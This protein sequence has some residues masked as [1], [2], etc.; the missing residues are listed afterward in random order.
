MPP[1]HIEARP[2]TDFAKEGLFNL[3]A[4][5]VDFDQVNALD[6]FSGTGSISLELVSRGCKSVTAI[7]QNEKHCA[8]IR[9]TCAEVFCPKCAENAR[10]HAAAEAAEINHEMDTESARRARRR[11]WIELVI[12]VP[13]FIGVIYLIVYLIRLIRGA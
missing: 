6:L 2:T 13:A 9:K 10:L 11:A 3:L 1:P 4:T 5:R 12:G 8:F 7:E